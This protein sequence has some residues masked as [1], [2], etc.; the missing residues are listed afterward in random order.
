M[1][2]NNQRL[3]LILAVLAGTAMLVVTLWQGY[4]FWQ[5]EKRQSAREVQQRQAPQVVSERKGP[6]ID[7]ASVALFGQPLQASETAPADTENLPE[8]NL[9]LFLRGVMAADGD[10]PGSALIED[11][12]RNTE[13]YLVGEELPGNARLRSIFPNRV[14][15]ERSGKLENLFFP[16]PEN[17]SGLDVASARPDQP[18]P[19]VDQPPIRTAPVVTPRSTSAEE[20]RETVRKRLEQLR[21]RLRTNN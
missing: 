5:A 17:R 3:P 18:E 21:A 9:R 11:D 12:D 13:A 10:F 1:R 16:E 14:I 8:T 20:R 19:A 2:L 15:I 7:L 6:E 4:S